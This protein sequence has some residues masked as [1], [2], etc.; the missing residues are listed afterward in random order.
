MRRWEYHSPVV[1]A[2]KFVCVAAVVAGVACG[3][4]RPAVPAVLS[5]GE[6]WQLSTRLSEPPGMFTHSEN[7]VS[8]ELQ[9]VQ[10]VRFLGASGGVYVGVGPEQNFS[11]I[12]GLG[13]D[14]AFIIDIRRENRNLHLLYK[15]LFEMSN[16]RVD[17]VSR[18]FSRERPVDLG[19]D[20]SV[21]HLFAAY[22]AARP[23][24]GLYETNRL[25]VHER[26]T[27][28]HAFPLTS[29][30]LNDIDRA[31]HAFFTHGP[32]ITYGPPSSENSPRPSYRTLMTAK[33]MTGESRSYLASDG[34]FAA[35]KALHV[36][37]RIVPV[38]GDFAGPTAIRGVAAYVK[39][40]GSRVTAFYGSNV[41]VYLN[42]VQMKAYCANLAA[43]PAN[44]RTWF[45][46]SR[47]MIPFAAK[48]KSCAGAAR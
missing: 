35:V 11:Y 1:R 31:L 47:G 14:M 4:H 33:D 5:D 36:S 7:L 18:L 9:F 40:R 16:D 23:A 29:H 15:A 48:L 30:D 24:A 22:A 45:I 21:Q 42:S 38:V 46:G 37:N 39:E 20:T 27:T 2:R 13:P 44:D 8:N 28:V 19:A 25:L 3:F 34:A 6:F 17:F 26:L 12:A 10:S 41:E 43:I 32:S